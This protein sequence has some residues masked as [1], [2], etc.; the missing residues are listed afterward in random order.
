VGGTRPNQAGLNAPGS[1]TPVEPVLAHAP[2]NAEKPR[3]AI[4]LIMTISCT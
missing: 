3:I 2:S 1:S 4:R